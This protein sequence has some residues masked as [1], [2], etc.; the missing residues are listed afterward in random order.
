M[1]SDGQSWF[2]NVHCTKQI[3]KCS[4]LC[5]RVAGCSGWIPQKKQIIFVVLQNS[6]ACT[7]EVECI[8]A[9][10]CIRAVVPVSEL[11]FVNWYRSHQQEFCVV[12]VFASIINVCLYKRPNNLSIS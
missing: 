11:W 10:D 4:F 7:S 8:P 6:L 12:F 2:L 9:S 5:I 1:S 3:T